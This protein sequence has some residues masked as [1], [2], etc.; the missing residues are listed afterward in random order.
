[1]VFLTDSRLVG[2]A[3]IQVWSLQQHVASSG[4]TCPL[5]SLCE[6]LGVHLKCDGAP[7]SCTTSWPWEQASFFL[8]SKQSLF[9]AAVDQP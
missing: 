8:Q 2:I 5:C 9:V 3:S 1:M 7:Y 4:G 6:L